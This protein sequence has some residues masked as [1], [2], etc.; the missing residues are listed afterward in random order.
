LAY[1][2]TTWSTGD[3]I[4]ATKLNNAE[5]QYDA[6]KADLDAHTGNTQNPHGVTRT[7]LNIL[8][9]TAANRPAA[10]T[11]GRRYFATDT[12]R[13][14]FDD[15]VSWIELDAASVGGKSGTNLVTGVKGSYTG[16]GVDRRLINIGLRPKLVFVF[17]ADLA[18]SSNG[19][20]ITL[21]GPAMG[22]AKQANSGYAIVQDAAY[23]VEIASSGFTLSAANGYTSQN[24]SG[25]IYHYYALV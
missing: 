24:R 15:G 11:V 18:S 7:Q 4:T 9:G 19:S 20:G 1:T 3:I 5:T 6:A 23:E 13:W 8:E 2:K 17:P 21:D 10:G 14:S 12:K 16:D 22:L 25:V